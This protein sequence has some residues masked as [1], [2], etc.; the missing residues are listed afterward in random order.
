[1]TTWPLSFASA[2]KPRGNEAPMATTRVHA[3]PPL[4]LALQIRLRNSQRCLCPCSRTCVSASSVFF[5]ASKHR[6]DEAPVATTRVCALPPLDLALQLR[7]PTPR[8]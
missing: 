4:Y 5:S 7:F 1:M 8:R 6:G 3:L 2:S